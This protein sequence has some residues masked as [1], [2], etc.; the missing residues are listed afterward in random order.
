MSLARTQI[1]FSV[2]RRLVRNQVKP[3]GIFVLPH[4]HFPRTPDESFTCGLYRSRLSPDSFISSA[5]HC[6]RKY[7]SLRP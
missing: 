5:T 6:S 4:Q 3:A 2:L 1:R 7:V